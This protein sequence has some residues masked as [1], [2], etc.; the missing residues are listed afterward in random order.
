MGTGVQKR[1]VTKTC[2]FWCLLTGRAK[3]VIKQMLFTDRPVSK[4]AWGNKW[5][6]KNVNSTCIFNYPLDLA[7][8]YV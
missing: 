2:L 1:F 7:T 4:N 5:K 8:S 3:T 6:R